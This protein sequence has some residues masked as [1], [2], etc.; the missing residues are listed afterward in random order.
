M[1][2]PTD[3][4]HRLSLLSI[5]QDSGQ[6]DV[7][8]FEHVRETLDAHLAEPGDAI[9]LTALDGDPIG[10]AYCVPEPVTVGTWNL[11]MLWLKQGYEGKGYGQSLLRNI[12]SE[13]KHR[14]ARLLIVETS[15]QEE[16]AAA[17]AFYEAS[18]F[19][20]EAEIKDFYDAG[21]HKLVYTKP[22]TQR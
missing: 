21:D 7:D 11:L 14:G 1:I 5:V 16:F 3:L 13:L 4:T 18:G 6:F 20:L 10:V 8:G 19:M 9:W 15:Q 2:V 22:M 17:R 12:E